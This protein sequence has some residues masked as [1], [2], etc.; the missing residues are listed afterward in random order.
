MTI[1][2]SSRSIQ[3]FELRKKRRAWEI[4]VGNDGDFASGDDA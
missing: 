4:V 3:L 2:D 1:G